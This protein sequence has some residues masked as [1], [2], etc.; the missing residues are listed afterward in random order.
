MSGAN[1]QLSNYQPDTLPMR[2]CCLDAIY[3]ICIMNKAPYS[4]VS[5]FKSHFLYTVA[6]THDLALVNDVA[7][8]HAVAVVAVSPIPFIASMLLPCPGRGEG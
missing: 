4:N 8:I 1:L 2:H 7:E 6:G 5:M 3:A